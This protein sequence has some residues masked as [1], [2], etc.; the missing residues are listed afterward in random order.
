[1]KN[2]Y[3]KKQV[4]KNA[5]VSTIISIESLIGID[6][7]EDMYDYTLDCGDHIYSLNS[8]DIYEYDEVESAIIKEYTLS[9]REIN[10]HDISQIVKSVLASQYRNNYESE[11]FEDYFN[12]IENVLSQYDW[13]F[14]GKEDGKSV[15]FAEAKWI[16]V[17]LTKK[18]FLSQFEN[19]LQYYETKVEF[20]DDAHELLENELS[21][22]IKKSGK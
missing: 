6:S 18:E 16:R 12:H 7:I 20:F 15:H 21:F 1:M 17:A 3:T 11:L 13:H 4:K 22:E 14:E 10:T 19:E 5:F 9:K 2:K 8:N